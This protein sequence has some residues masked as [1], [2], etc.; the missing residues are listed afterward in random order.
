VTVSVSDLH[1]DTFVD[2]LRLRWRLDATDG[3]RDV[4]QAWAEVEVLDADSG[5]RRWS[6]GRVDGA[7]QSIAYGGPMLR[8][9]DRLTWRV[10]AGLRERGDTDWSDTA[11]IEVP[12]LAADDWTARLITSEAATPVF[13]ST[14]SLGAEVDRARLY[15]SGHGVYEVS[16]N[17]AVVGDEVLAPGWTSYHH[18]LAARAHDVAAL[19]HAGENKVAITVADGWWRGRLGFRPRREVYG[20]RVGVIAQL[21]ATL[22]DGSIVTVATDESWSVG[23]GPTRSADLYDGERYD[24]RV[25][26]E[27]DRGAAVEV[28]D[29][30]RSLLFF[31][32]VPPIRRVGAVTP[33]DV[34]QR[35][36]G[37]WI[38]DFGQNIVGRLR[39][40]FAGLE[41]GDEVTLR[42]AEVLDPD[43]ELFTAPL[44]TAKATDHYLAAGDAAVDATPWEPRFTFHGFRYAELSA[45][46]SFDLQRA[47]L[48]AIVI[49]SDLEATGTFACSDP[50][51]SQLYENVNRSWRGNSV[52]VP[53]DC[54]QRDERLGW[55]GDAQVFSPTAAFLTDAEAFFA[56]WLADLAADQRAS[57][58]AVPHVIPHM[59]EE[60]WLGA[61]GWGDAAIVVP[62]S[63]Y[64]AYGDEAVLRASWPSIERWVG[65]VWGRLD[66]ELV[67]SKDFQFG[68]WLDPD[69]PQ[70][71]PFKAKARFDLVAT[72]HAA[73]IHRLAARIAGVLGDDGAST[74]ASRANELSGAWWSRFGEAAVKT[75]TGCAMALQFSLAPE[76]ERERVGSRLAALVEETDNHLATGFLGT[77]LLCPALTATGRVDLA[78]KVLLQDTPPSWLFQVKSGATTIWERWDCTRPDVDLSMVSFN[79]YAYGAI[80]D[81]LHRTVAGLAPDAEDPGFHHVLVAPKPG[82]G[83]TSASASLQSRHGLT[84]VAWE[85]GDDASFALDV[86]IPPNASATVTLPDGSEP[87][88]VGSGTHSFKTM[89]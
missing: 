47:D 73:W 43:G 87:V 40:T 41:R 88:R 27:V 8:S 37:R 20:D 31:S 80:A 48:R 36:P 33:V 51:V 17:G 60:P 69:A 29:F 1:A 82:G 78:Y 65:Y 6:S 42:H 52:D 74:Y 71:K 7:R 24:A 35:E 54:P 26:V 32:D 76:S 49:T 19:L 56:S 57:D 83:F 66:D 70:D 46:A 15:I 12:L 11:T 61:A 79:H 22:A 18:R 4:E 72:A 14:F 59:M 39:G 45:P 9:R 23:S 67:W 75:Q 5:N 81:W 58:G 28:S 10:R 13:S 55:T 62:W 84:S 44:R 34:E 16:I 50:L 2:P 25:A 30:D 85:L 77:P 86:V 53:T 64:E 21:E 63:V 68:D 3:E 38:I 89:L